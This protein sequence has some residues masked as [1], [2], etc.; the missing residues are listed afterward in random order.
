VEERKQPRVELAQL[1]AN[2]AMVKPTLEPAMPSVAPSGKQALGGGMGA[3]ECAG[4]RVWLW[5]DGF[6]WSWA[7]DVC[8]GRRLMAGD[9][10]MLVGVP[11][12]RVGR[13]WRR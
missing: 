4:I 6:W 5:E 12:W 11:A 8:G 13:W 1:L 3:A 2:W 10:D 9:V 7:N